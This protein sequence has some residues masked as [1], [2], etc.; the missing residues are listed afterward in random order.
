MPYQL[1]RLTME[2][3][4]YDPFYVDLFVDQMGS[5]Y[6]KIQT[7]GRWGRMATKESWP[8]ILRPSGQNGEAQFDFGAKEG[9]EELPGPRQARSNLFSKSIG[10][11][12][13]VTVWYGVD[14][15]CCR[16]TRV[17]SLPDGEKF[18]TI[19]SSV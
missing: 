12:E 18:Y 19:A 9:S 17:I 11:N 14:E 6:P 1:V 7:Y 8:F 3:S 5:P 10:E 13:I 4:G 15:I 2:C 16:I